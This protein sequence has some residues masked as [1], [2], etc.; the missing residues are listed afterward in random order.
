ME[1]KMKTIRYYDGANM[2]PNATLV[3]QGPGY[4]AAIVQGD[5]TSI[6][7]I[8]GADY[9]GP[10]PQATGG[11]GT[12]SYAETPEQAAGFYAGHEVTQ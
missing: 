1:D 7:K 8:E 5:A 10:W 12:I 2:Y 9:E 11:F 4:Y 6:M 3:W